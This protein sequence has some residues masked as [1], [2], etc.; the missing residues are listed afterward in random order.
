MPIVEGVGDEVLY[1]ALAAAATP[2][3]IALSPSYI[4]YVLLFSWTR[5]M[6]NAA[7]TQQGPVPKLLIPEASD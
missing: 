7:I 6:V 1:A 4:R 5:S 3:A 2:L